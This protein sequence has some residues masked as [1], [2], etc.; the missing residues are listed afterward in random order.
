MSILGGGG[1]TSRLVEE[2]RSKRGLSYSVYSYFFP[3]RQPGPFV[4]G[5]QTRSDQVQQ[6]MDVC[7]QVLRD[8]IKNGPTQEELDLSKK[9][10]IN[11]FP[12]R[13]GSNSDIL[14]Y[15]SL[16]GYYNL[17]LTYL[18]DFTANIEKVTLQTVREA[19][20]KHV[21]VD[22]FV[23]VIVGSEKPKE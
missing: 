20:A 1:F 7:N 3:Y 17:P 14:G 15:L 2:V 16:I 10:I 19:F 12:L 5:L 9:S 23:T 13:I 18:N 4:L 11:G 22:S 8:Y 6:A 21:N